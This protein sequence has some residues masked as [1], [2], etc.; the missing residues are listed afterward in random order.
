MPSNTNTDRL[1]DHL[2]KNLTRLLTQLELIV[3]LRQVLTLL[4]QMDEE[5]EEPTVELYSSKINNGR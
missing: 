2:H 4:E 5:E 1:E 3:K